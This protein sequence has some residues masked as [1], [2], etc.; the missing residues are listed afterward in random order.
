MLD[1]IGGFERIRRFMIAQIETSQRIRD[2]SAETA[3]RTLLDKAGAYSA[4]PLLEFLPRYAPASF[5]LEKMLDPFLPNNPLAHFTTSAREA[6]V[7]LVL[8]GLFES[9]NDPQMPSSKKSLYPPYQHQVDMLR[10]GTHPGK[11]AFV[12]S[13]TGSGKTESFMLPILATLCAE[14]V[15]WPIPPD[16]THGNGWFMGE[17]PFVPRRAEENVNRPQG[18]RALILYP[19][20][21][22]VEDQLTR[23]RRALDCEAAQEVMLSHFHGNRLY[24]GR[25]NSTT[26]L[27]G[28]L[29][30]PRINTLQ[31]RAKENKKVEQLR[32]TLRGMQAQRMAAEKYDRLKPGDEEARHL[33]SSLDGSELVTRWDM[34]LSP[35]DILITN[36]SMLSVMMAREVE[37][38]IFEKTRQWLESSD[39]AY[40]FLVL[41]EM[42]LIRGSGG[43][44]T[45]NLLRALIHKLG[46]ADPKHRHKLRLLGSSASLP[47]DGEL[48]T[49]S[50]D[51]LYDFFGPLGSYTGLNSSGIQTS[52]GWQEAIVPGLS[53]DFDPGELEFHRAHLPLDPV[54]F[55]DLA[56][57]LSEKNEPYVATRLPEE[58][59]P[60]LDAIL[61]A[62]FAALGTQG[63]DS[64]KGLPE[65]VSAT[66]KILSAVLPL[67]KKVLDVETIST[68]IFGESPSV[69]RSYDESQGMK[70]LRGLCI[71][72]SFTDK[73]R[74]PYSAYLKNMPLPSIRVHAFIRSLAG[75]YGVPVMMPEKQLT[76]QGL[77]STRGCLSTYIDNEEHRLFELVYCTACGELFVGGFK[78][79]LDGG[80]TA[81]SIT[82]R[83]NNSM[84]SAALFER[85]ER[86]PFEDYALFWVPSDGGVS[87]NEQKNEKWIEA[88]L[89]TRNGLLKTGLKDIEDARSN[90]KHQIL[91]YMFQLREEQPK[92][93]TGAQQQKSQRQQPG[94][95][96]P[97]HCPRC[98]G[99]SFRK[100]PDGQFQPSSTLRN[101]QT[102]YLTTSQRL[103]TELCDLLHSN[104][105]KA[106]SLAFFDSRQ[107][108]ARAA[109]GISREHHKDL[110]RLLLLDILDAEIE[111]SSPDA[112]QRL[113]NQRAT[114]SEADEWEDVTRLTALIKQMESIGKSGKIPLGP[115]L[116]GPFNE[117]ER[118]TRRYLKGF[119]DL[120]A[121][122]FNPA[123]VDDDEG[124]PWYSALESHNGAWRWKYDAN[125]GVLADTR[126]RVRQNQTELLADILFS[127]TVF[128]L[129][130]TGLG[131]VS[132][133]K[134]DGGSTSNQNDAFLRVFA[135]ESRIY[136]MPF[137]DP[138]TKRQYHP[139]EKLPA[140]SRVHRFATAIQPHNPDELIDN[141]LNIFAD[142]N[143]QYGFITLANLSI[144][145]VKA[146]EPYYRCA[147]CGR[148]HLHKGAG[149]CTRCF[150]CLPDA[151]SGTASDLW[152]RHFLAQKI[153][154][155]ADTAKRA[156]RL[157]CHELTGQTESPKQRLQE[158]KGIFISEANTTDSELR[159]KTT[160]VDVLAVTTTME[161]G[162][163]IG[164]IQA[165]F[166]GNMPP[167][168]FNY[169]Q[170][171]GRAGRRGQA[172]SF[173]LTLC[174]NQ[175]HDMHYFYAPEEIVALPP[176]PPFIT[177]GHEEIPL[178]IIIKIWLGAAF[179][180][181]R[182]EDA[183]EAGEEYEEDMISDVHGEFPQ[184]RA[185]YSRYYPERLRAALEQTQMQRDS[186]IN[187]LLLGSSK[188]EFAAA[189]KALTDTA[190]VMDNLGKLQEKGK[191]CIKPFGLFLAEN[192]L[193]PLYGMP[194][195]IRSL[196]IGLDRKSKRL[197]SIDLPAE[198]AI[199]EFAS[200]QLI[201]RDK[202][203]YRCQGLAPS[204]YY[205]EE[206]RG[207]QASG[208]WYDEFV[209]IARCPHCRSHLN[210][211]D[212]ADVSCPLCGG[213]VT[214]GEFHSYTVP[215]GFVAN[216]TPVP[217]READEESF[218]SQVTD[219]V[220]VHHPADLRHITPLN[221][222]LGLG[223]D[224]TFLFH[225]NKGPAEKGF[226]FTEFTGSNRWKTGK[227]HV[228]LPK[229]AISSETGAEGG[230]RRITGFISRKK[231]DAAF[232]APVSL[233]KGI[234]LPLPDES[235]YNRRTKS[236]EGAAISATQI[237][238]LR[239]CL[240]FDIANSEFETL[241]P[242]M[243]LHMP[244]IQ[245]ADLL[246]NGSG[247]CRR[248]AEARH[249]KKPM[250]A[251]L[252]ESMIF[253]PESD[254]LVSHF[255]TKTHKDACRTSCYDCLQQYDNRQFHSILDWR[256]GISFLRLLTDKDWQ[257]GLDGNWN[258]FE[259][260]DWPS[261]ARSAAQAIR[262]LLP[263]RLIVE[264]AIAD[265][266]TIAP[267]VR[268][269]ITEKGILIGHPFWTPED[270][271]DRTKTSRCSD[272]LDSF[273]ALRWP[274]EALKFL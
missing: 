51:Y 229:V 254:R 143:H 119:L 68:K 185:V 77:T 149:I 217:L 89:D 152:E 197:L 209:W 273:T 11:P 101:F 158:F 261:H 104:D 72:R 124:E 202:R 255:I 193:L 161:V 253:T 216:F 20:N 215:N 225:L 196:Y 148:V 106:K 47:L 274:F 182:K 59:D 23:L 220:L 146:E 208:Q 232:L 92:L 22:L 5:V 258:F 122:P 171:A 140:S 219:A 53:V 246:P 204:L 74:S 184:T 265:T 52:E 150:N 88:V 206:K 127:R 268:N 237:L 86:T 13:G 223:T 8:S 138:E 64:V 272:V 2:K 250:A 27:T 39:D 267:I 266:Y 248:L 168:R 56:A 45:A 231:T 155:N 186:L 260:E 3:R 213:I 147:R 15:N 228:P 130:E 141:V 224:N 36:S 63:S 67:D 214:S 100:R 102:P 160:E 81:L 167:Q 134:S 145:P 128:A 179:D 76:W 212:A 126:E 121:H 71:L 156:F 57:R 29:R 164:A 226:C 58:R 70:A 123:G 17:D 195:N 62:C 107:G 211:A 84:A 172:F 118:A 136:G 112:L 25:Y 190:A 33:F 221:L 105:L 257:V 249:A 116:E 32:A 93:K 43:A 243:L 44:E 42:H 46:L 99:T 18:V 170:R 166:Q 35:P 174:R 10:R 183:Y 194:T 75:L 203:V 144:R 49:Q 61:L 7:E 117:S 120:G 178:R 132:L 218:S 87:R 236:I 238:T 14:A 65:A 55:I 201:T 94:S 162:V 114:A 30:H 252:L 40:F 233:A 259:L 262:S 153:M 242:K 41:D 175:S 169:Q 50:L 159:Q 264:E 163:D 82:K 181:L 230:G 115:L 180:L 244:T 235:E 24:F 133:D 12:V 187:V 137:F 66:A 60:V 16:Q 4:A 19:M 239:A 85:F 48:R 21:A 103:V 245:L 6:F 263:D 270:I 192:G 151:V 79:R 96:L 154:R 111:S 271:L 90:T 188:P 38:S 234:S 131:W 210:L 31:Q 189:V 200:P 142:A 73:R 125:H 191:E 251:N 69:C 247:F 1:P 97:H 37:N 256:L 26:P 54:P 198:R 165:I 177:T 91:G 139:G 95:A 110:C 173:V 199:Q 135:D 113:K 34:Q 109:L 28:F 269:T 205:S 98:G 241:R 207:V 78:H 222:N 240:E 83:E 176:P 9:E 129:E 80:A 157:N 108:A 227:Q